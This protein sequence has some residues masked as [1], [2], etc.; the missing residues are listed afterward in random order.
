MEEI[1]QVKTELEELQKMFSTKINQ[2]NLLFERIL[3]NQQLILSEIQ[4][5]RESNI[6]DKAVMTITN[7]KEI[8]G[9]YGSSMLVQGIDEK[10]NRYSF[11][12]KKLLF[13]MKDK[14]EVDFLEK[15]YNAQYKSMNLK[16]VQNI[17]LCS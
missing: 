11:F 6:G 16:K 8:D 13:K 2:L 10:E 4:E 14:I 3:K 12:T 15:E 5:K 9:P 1:N 17:K 7:T